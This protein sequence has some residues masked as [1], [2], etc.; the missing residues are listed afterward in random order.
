MTR[1]QSLSFIWLTNVVRL[2]MTSVA[3]HRAIGHSDLQVIL[4][5]AEARN[6]HA[7]AFWNQVCK[8]SD[9]GVRTGLDSNHKLRVVSGRG[10]GCELIA[11]SQFRAYGAWERESVRNTTQHCSAR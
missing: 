3:M 4:Q 2:T 8:S 1:C 5:E 11:F 9:C 7:L 10:G 6:H